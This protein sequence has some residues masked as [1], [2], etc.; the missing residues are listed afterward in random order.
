MLHSEYDK[1]KVM[2]SARVVPSPYFIVIETGN[3][4]GITI[5]L[6][7]NDNKKNHRKSQN[8]IGF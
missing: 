1:L 7:M 2:R 5:D 8:S 6:E 3:A 4:K